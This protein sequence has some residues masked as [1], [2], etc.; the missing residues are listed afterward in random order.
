[1]INVWRF[2]LRKL[3]GVSKS[4]KFDGHFRAGFSLH[5]F[6][7]PFL[8]AGRKSRPYFAYALLA[9]DISVAPKR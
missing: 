2:K 4:G 1:M 6:K 7:M 3:L 5:Q 9:V 8:V